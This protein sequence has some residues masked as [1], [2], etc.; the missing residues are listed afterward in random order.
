MH[1][2]TNLPAA[3]QGLYL[4]LRLLSLVV[5]NFSQVL[6]ANTFHLIAENTEIGV[7]LTVP[8]FVLV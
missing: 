7:V 6:H 4:G 1:F 8:F 3:V 5:G 2:S